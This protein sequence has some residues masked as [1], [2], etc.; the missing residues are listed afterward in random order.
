M[1]TIKNY[2]DNMFSGLP[3]TEE[4]AKLK[5]DIYENMQEKYQELKAS[6]KSENEAIGIVISEFG[7]IEEILDEFGI[8]HGERGGEPPVKKEGLPEVTMEVAKDYIRLKKMAG[9]FIG[10]GVFLCIVGIA[11]VV[12]FQTLTENIS[13][14]GDR[15][16]IQDGRGVAVG[17]I[18]MFV[19]IAGGV[20]LFIYSG[21]L[22][23]P[24]EY[25]EKEFNISEYTQQQIS[26]EWNVKK[27]T[28]IVRLVTGI[29]MCV[30][31]PIPI[32]I[33]SFMGDGKDQATTIGVCFMMVIVATAVYLIISAGNVMDSYF[34]I[35]EL[36]DYRPSRK[37][38]NKAVEIVASIVWP[39][40]TVVYLYLGFVQGM[41]HPGWVIFPITGVLF[42]VFS[43]IVEAIAKK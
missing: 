41:W 8:A 10:I 28:E 39:L 13:I 9:K 14:A 15:I 20:A 4:M 11:L 1:E 37:K 23:S 24:Y 35:L 40:V 6:G 16:G 7:N 25:M 2:L 31:S 5:E 38:A 33:G 30:L 34:K 18:I 22:L 12:A 42:G 43:A 36:G 3:K 21:F 27:A 26:A 32:F 19:F 29:C 17:L